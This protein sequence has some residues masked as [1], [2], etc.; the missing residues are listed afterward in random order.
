MLLFFSSGGAIA[1]A[2]FTSSPLRTRFV[3]AEK[4]LREL[5]GDGR[6][7]FVEAEKR[8]RELAGDGRARKIEA[9]SRNNK[10]RK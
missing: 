4:R 2:V 8:L 1:G 7:R 5:A 10:V 9:E 6:T 3:E